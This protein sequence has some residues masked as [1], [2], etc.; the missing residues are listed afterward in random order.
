MRYDAIHKLPMRSVVKVDLTIFFRKKGN[1]KAVAKSF[2][3][4]L[5]A[6]VGSVLEIGYGRNLL[7]QFPEF[8]YQ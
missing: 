8:V 5:R 7:R 2:M 3:Q 1:Q 4:S 6:I